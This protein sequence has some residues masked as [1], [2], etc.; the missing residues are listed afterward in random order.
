MSREPTDTSTT[1][2]AATEPPLKRSYLNLAIRIVWLVVSVVLLHQFY[3]VFYAGS[4][5][6]ASDPT[7]R[8]LSELEVK[9]R[10]KSRQAFIAIADIVTVACVL[11]LAVFK[12]AG[13][14]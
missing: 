5:H 11:L 12:R 13:L 2:T 6:D 7:A 1:T 10:V 9:L 14:A 3:I 4:I 8:Q